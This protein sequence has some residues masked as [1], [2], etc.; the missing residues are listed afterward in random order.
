MY[1][2][3]A[4]GAMPLMWAALEMWK[5]TALDPWTGWVRTIGCSMGRPYFSWS[6][7]R[8]STCPSSPLKVV[9]DSRRPR[10]SSG[11]AR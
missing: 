3:L 4:S 7:G 1:A 9:S 6:S 8:V 2:R 11:N 10:S 5:Y